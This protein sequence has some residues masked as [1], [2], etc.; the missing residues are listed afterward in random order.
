[1]PENQ[2]VNIS[3][4]VFRALKTFEDRKFSSIDDYRFYIAWSMLIHH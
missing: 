1:M 4:F 2:I 3:P